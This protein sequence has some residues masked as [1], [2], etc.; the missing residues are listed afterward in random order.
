[1][2]VNKFLMIV[3]LL[4]GFDGEAGVKNLQREEERE[5]GVWIGK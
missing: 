5:I 3:V 1:V 4:C 2:E